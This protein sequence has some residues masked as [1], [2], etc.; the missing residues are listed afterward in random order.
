MK[1]LSMYKIECD[2]YLSRNTLKVCRIVWC[3]LLFSSLWSKHQT[4]ATYNRKHLGE[5]VQRIQS[6]F[7]WLFTLRRN[8]IA[9][10][11]V[12]L[13]RVLVLCKSEN[14]RR[15][16]D[17]VLLASLLSPFNSVQN[18]CSSDSADHM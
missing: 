15:K 11:G 12:W 9:I 17:G 2:G 18:P 8:K 6:N 1:L 10:G 7:V 14:G 5:G 16:N 13:R 3:W 4:E